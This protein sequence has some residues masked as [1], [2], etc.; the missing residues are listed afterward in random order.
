[1]CPQAVV[2]HVSFVF[3]SICPVLV[4]FSPGGYQFLFL[5]YCGVV[6]YVKFSKLILRIT[7]QKLLKNNLSS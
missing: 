6:V 5:F 3:V 2:K 1:M 4:T 7:I